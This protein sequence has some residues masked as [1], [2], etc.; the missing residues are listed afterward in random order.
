[1]SDFRGRFL[2]YELLTT[3]PDHAK[4]FY[5]TVVG[6]GTDRWPGMAVPYTIWTRGGVPIGG[7]MELPAEA[8]AQGAPTHWLAYIGTPDVDKTVAS[9]VKSG[10]RVWVAPRDIP[11][12]GRF[13]VLADPGGAMFAAYKPE[14]DPGPETAPTLADCSWNEIVA[15]DPAPSWAFFSGLFGWEK[16]GE[17]HDMGPMGPYQEYGR[18]GD[19]RPLGG[20]FKKPA[21]IPGPPHLMLYFRVADVAKSAEVVLA[22][23]GQVLHG[24]VEVPGGDFILMCLDPQGGAFALHHTTR[25]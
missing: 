22:Q 14:A 8:K 13:A 3:D 24:P 20:I 23:G 6:W 19:V 4:A 11:A 18:P 7:L 1:M 25:S 10:G 12:V 16:K 21:E 5:T 9:A 17:A 2:W 15:A